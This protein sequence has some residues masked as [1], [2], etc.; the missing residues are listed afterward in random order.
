[1]IFVSGQRYDVE[2]VQD[3]VELLRLGLRRSQWLVANQF[4]K[5]REQRQRTDKFK[6]ETNGPP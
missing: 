5:E 1:V 6:T 2:A 4:V 3:A